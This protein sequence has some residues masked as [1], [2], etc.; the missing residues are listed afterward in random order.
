MKLSSAIADAGLQLGALDALLHAGTLAADRL[1]PA[2]VAA[3]AAIK[4]EPTFWNGDELELGDDNDYEMLALAVVA[5]GDLEVTEAELASVTSISFDGGND[6]Y[7]WLEPA[8]A[9]ALGLESYQLDT[10]GESETYV[11]K[12]LDG[13]AG[14]PALEQLSL[15]AYGYTAQTRPLTPLRGHR[16]LKR[17]VLAG[18]FSD[19]EALLACPALASV[20]FAAHEP[21]E[22]SVVEALRKKGVEVV[23]R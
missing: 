15:D 16:A 1:E 4:A 2:L 20:Q 7:M 3:K 22:P 13:I 12:S 18:K 21:L 19:P 11:V 8:L 6:I 14:L 23:E 5:L 9:D 10:G 17:I